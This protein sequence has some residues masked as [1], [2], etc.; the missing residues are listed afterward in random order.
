MRQTNVK[1]TRSKTNL[2]QSISY[3]FGVNVAITYDCLPYFNRGFSGTIVA[4]TQVVKMNKHIVTSRSCVRTYRGRFCRF[5]TLEIGLSYNLHVVLDGGIST[6]S[7]G[8]TI[9]LE[10][11]GISH[12]WRK[13]ILILYHF[14]PCDIG[15]WDI[16]LWTCVTCSSTLYIIADLLQC[17][18]VYVLM[19]VGISRIYLVEIIDSFPVLTFV[20]LL[21]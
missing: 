2:A 15:K 20:H 18:L 3:S 7:H 9:K 14:W 16:S 8:V 13:F 1:T 4:F 5:V 6:C 10:V 12:S 19:E 21:N 17:D 11:N